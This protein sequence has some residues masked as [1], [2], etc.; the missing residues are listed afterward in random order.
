MPATHEKV[1]SMLDKLQ[2]AAGQKQSTH[3][4]E[5]KTLILSRQTISKYL[6]RFFPGQSQ[7]IKKISETK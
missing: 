4:Q 3:F 6:K 5:L 2:M 7:A 1:H